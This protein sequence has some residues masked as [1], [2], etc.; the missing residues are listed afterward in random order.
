MLKIFA[1]YNTNEKAAVFCHQ[2]QIKAIQGSLSREYGG[3]WLLIDECMTG[4]EILKFKDDQI[5]RGFE[6]GKP[7]DYRYTSSIKRFKP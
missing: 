3:D 4:G 6:S 5:Y 2:S 1:K 7:L